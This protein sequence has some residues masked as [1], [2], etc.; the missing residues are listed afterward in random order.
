MKTIC[1]KSPA[2]NWAQAFPVG[3]GRLGAMVWGNP[4]HEI[5]QINEE[6]VWSSSFIDRNN[7]GCRKSLQ[8]INAFVKEG[9]NAEAQD[10]L[11][12][13]FDPLVKNHAMS[14]PYA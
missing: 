8:K 3:N 4:A 5:I 6:S 13:S 12:T 1:S 11:R 9:R 10:L 2:E 7:P 14:M